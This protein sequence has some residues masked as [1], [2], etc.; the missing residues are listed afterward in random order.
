MQTQRVETN[1]ILRICF[2]PTVV[3]QTLHHFRAYLVAWF[4]ELVRQE[5]CDFEWLAVAQV[6]CLENRAQGALGC[7]WVAL[8]EL[9]IGAQH[10][11]EVLRPRSIGSRVHDDLPDL[12][13]PHF[14]G[15][16][17]ESDDS[18]RPAR[19]ESMHRIQ[20]RSRPRHPVNLG[21]VDPDI[22]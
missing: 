18:I 1:R 9:P 6:C 7:H 2:A 17:S 15:L 22:R 11:A 13:G 5:A 14:Y 3:R 10:A 12:P 8:H 4:V 19:R 16:L 20:Q 21:W